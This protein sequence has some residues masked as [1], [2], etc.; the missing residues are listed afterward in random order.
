MTFSNDVFVPRRCSS[1][2]RMMWITPDRIFY[3]GLLGAPALHTKGAIIVYIA[4][5]GRLKVRIAG[6][7]WQSAEVAVVQ[8][9]VPYEVACEGRHVLDIL[10]EPETVNLDRL[11]P[12]LRA[13]GAVDAY[14]PQERPVAVVVVVDE[15]RGVRVGAHVGQPSQGE[16]GLRLGVHRGDDRVV[17][18]E[19]EAAGNQV[20]PA[21]VGDRAQPGH[22]GG[23]EAP[24]C[25]RGVH[26]D[27]S[28]RRPSVE[29]TWSASERRP[30]IQSRSESSFAS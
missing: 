20:R 14:P 16:G 2:E 10:I 30:A 22:P 7:D 8:P 9:F 19:R 29:V 12:L 1:A 28:A 27:Q 15:D 6:G 4:I 3:A 18:D 5:E 26:G 24:A 17:V 23:G 11:P 13:C 21:V 25:D